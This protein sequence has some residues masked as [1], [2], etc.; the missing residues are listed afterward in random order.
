[1]QQ[2]FGQRG[3]AVEVVG[4]DQL[5]GSLDK[6]L[7]D[8]H[9]TLRLGPS[10]DQAAAAFDQFLEDYHRARAATRAGL[11]H[12]FKT[13]GEGRLHASI[14]QQLAQPRPDRR[15]FRPHGFSTAEN[16]GQH[17]LGPGWIEARKSKAE[18]IDHRIGFVDG[19]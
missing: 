7:A 19:G 8:F 18:A 3:F 17:F 15:F 6:S 14:G 1:M 5:V 12:G 4:F 11:N 13:A 2:Q 16:L 10:S 9:L